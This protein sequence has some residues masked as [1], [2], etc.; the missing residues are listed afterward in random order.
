MRSVER[1]RRGARTD[2]PSI[3][4]SAVCLCESCYASQDRSQ[5]SHRQRLSLSERVYHCPC[6]DLTLDR[7]HKAAW[8]ISRVGRHALALARSP[9]T[10]PLGVVTKGQL[11]LRD[12]EVS[13][14]AIAYRLAYLGH[15]TQVVCDI[16]QGIEV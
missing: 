4:W 3:Y 8:N 15:Q 16:V 14:C 6:Y 5:H 12:G 13:Q 11:K 9:R 10:L 2:G 7:A 1:S